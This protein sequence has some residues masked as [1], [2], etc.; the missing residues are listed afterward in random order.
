[1]DMSKEWYLASAGKQTGPFTEDEVKG[2]IANGN[3]GPEHYVFKKGWAE[4][5]PI[6]AV[7]AFSDLLVVPPPPP[8]PSTSPPRQRIV[9]DVDPP[10]RTGSSP[11]LPKKR[12]KG[13]KHLLGGIVIGGAVLA[14]TLIAT[15]DP[16]MAAGAGVLAFVGFLLVVG[17]KI[18]WVSTLIAMGGLGFRYIDHEPAR[19]AFG[20]NASGRIDARLPFKYYKTFEE[21]GMENRSAIEA[22]RNE[23]V[24]RPLC[25]PNSKPDCFVEELRRDFFSLNPRYF[26]NL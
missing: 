24:F 17:S 23:Y 18:A 2:S 13:L 9:D 6:S 20:V 25:N 4:W 7:S 14:A 5:R 22:H 10:P 16:M 21:C 3:A 26:A 11:A 15:S 8:P 19:F 1:M 12:F